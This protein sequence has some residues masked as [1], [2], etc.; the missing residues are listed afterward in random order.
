MIMEIL[1][2]LNSPCHALA[3]A[4]GL[5]SLFALIA[6]GIHL[7]DDHPRWSGVCLSMTSWV[8]CYRFSNWLSQPLGLPPQYG[9]LCKREIQEKARGSV[10]AVGISFGMSVAVIAAVVAT[11]DGCQMLREGIGLARGEPLMVWWMV[12]SFFAPYS[13]IWG[14]RFLSAWNDGR[15]DEKSCQRCLRRWCVQVP[16]MSYAIWILIILPFCSIPQLTQIQ[17]TNLAKASALTGFVYLVASALFF[18]I[19]VEFYDSASGWRGSRLK[20]V[21]SETSVRPPNDGI[22]LRFHLASLASNLY[23]FGLTFALV[24]V[25]LLLCLVSLRVGCTAAGLSLG[26]VVTMLESERW[27]WDNQ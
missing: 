8:T 10:G 1:Q 26:V 25:S 22:A 14:Q 4:G 23:V 24:G 18:L 21:S 7:F 6:I 19:S 15:K 2:W 12:S 11:K 17:Q 27:L 16:S 13:V 20:S 9:K 5:L 3:L